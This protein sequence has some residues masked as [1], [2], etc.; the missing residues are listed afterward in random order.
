MPADLNGHA[1]QQQY[2][3]Q[4]PWSNYMRELYISRLPPTLGHVSID[5][6]EQMAREKLKEHASMS[7]LF[8]V[9]LLQFR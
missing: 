7:D 5:E 1:I 3:V 8:I 2:G 6:I 4:K 9:L